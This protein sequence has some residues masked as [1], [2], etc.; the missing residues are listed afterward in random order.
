MDPGS[1]SPS[2]FL[3]LMWPDSLCDCLVVET[4]H[5]ARSKGRPNW[6]DVNRDEVWTFLTLN[7]LLST[8][9]LTFGV[10]MGIWVLRK[11]R[12]I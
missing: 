5:Y 4:N 6:E 11:A 10:G 7:L 3:K 8:H 12:S 9:R 1:T 2:D